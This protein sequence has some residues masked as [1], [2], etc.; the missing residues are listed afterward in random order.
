VLLEALYVMMLSAPLTVAVVLPG[1]PI[2]TG[3]PAGSVICTVPPVVAG[4]V[5]LVELVKYCQYP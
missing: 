4:T 3:D 5:E 1:L 2:I